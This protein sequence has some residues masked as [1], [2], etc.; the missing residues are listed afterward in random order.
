MSLSIDELNNMHLDVLREIGNI[1]AGNAATALAK[2]LNKKVDMAVPKAQIL[3]FKKVTDLLGG[4]DSIVVGILL[5]V[6][7]DLTGYIMFIL[8]QKYAHSLVNMLMG[9]DLDHIEEFGEMDISALKEIGNI[10]SGAYLSSLS[11]L[12]NLTILPSIPDLTIDMAG[13]ILSVPAIE[14]GKVGDTV[15]F[16]ETEFVEDNSTVVGNFFLIPDMDSYDIL[17]KALGV[18]D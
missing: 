7:G 3:E 16:I 9:K 6:T 2:L 11:S 8:E 17:L 13:A 1:G 5:S 18:V 14:F 15:L 10:L 12:T 4:A